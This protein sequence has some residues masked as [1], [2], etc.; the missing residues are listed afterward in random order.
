MFNVILVTDTP[1]RP[2][3]ARG[4]GA[5]R[6]AS[7]I[8]QY[9]G[10]SCLVVDF[11]SDMLWHQWADIC[12][13]T[14]SD[15]TLVLG[16]STTWWPNHSF[17]TGQ[18]APNL[19]GAG[20]GIP[21]YTFTGAA[22]MGRLA[23]WIAEAKKYNPKLK[24]VVG[25]P[26][27]DHYA[28]IRADHYFAGYAE[29]EFMDYL[30]SL[31]ND[32]RIWPRVIKHDKNGDNFNFTGS[33]TSY[34]D[35]DFIRP[36]EFLTIEFTR[37]CRFK[38]SFCSYRLIGRKDI[39]EKY[40][41]TPD[42]I[43]RE[44]MEN[45]ERWGVTSYQVADDTFNDTMEK[46]E[47]IHGVTSRLPFK[48]N[49][50]AYTRLDLAATHPEMIPLLKE[51]GLRNTWIGL[52]SMHP[53]GSKVIG[54]GMNVDKKKAALKMIRDIWADDVYVVAGYI[55][56][57]P[58][59]SSADLRETMDW[60]CGEDSPID[61]IRLNPLIISP[62]TPDN[63]NSSHSDMDINYRE[64]GYEIPDMTKSWL[65]TKDDG[66]DIRTFADA[67]RLANEHMERIRLTLNRPYDYERAGVEHPSRDYFAPLI[68]KL[69]GK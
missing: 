7:H 5:H 26:K 54:K 44:F 24:I 67:E 68:D 36:D 20:D 11:A 39:T 19:D 10:Y 43:Y 69:K 38:C 45:Y 56:G 8:R 37:G 51:I 63:P 16:I 34:T 31:Q 12:K 61:E 65:W 27:I 32:K 50:K 42:T 17:K 64:Y 25:G 62:P 9:G 13:Y 4:A 53:V 15:D 30:Q 58:G 55:V 28:D 1:G 2:K 47:I 46:L 21:K 6:I 35:Y 57:L 59:E 29:S 18:S 49:L 33:I 66:T 48:L 60:C 40:M 22:G 23:K 52:D 14:V 3:W 41:K